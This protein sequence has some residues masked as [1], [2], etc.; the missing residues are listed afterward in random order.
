[1][2]RIVGLV[3]K[4]VKPL[5]P[6]LDDAAQDKIF[7]AIVPDAVA[8]TKMPKID[9]GPPPATL[10]ATDKVSKDEFD[11]V[12]IRVGKILEAHAIP[13]KDRLLKL[14]VDLGEPKPRTIVAGI[15]QH[16][17]PETLV[18]K[19]ALSPVEIVRKPLAPD[20]AM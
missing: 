15:A 13:K 11:R 10:P 2:H 1:M 14:I 19:H 18:G 6:R 7:R 9:V 8:T 4:D 20:R 5:F 17:K 16:H 3:K 12:E